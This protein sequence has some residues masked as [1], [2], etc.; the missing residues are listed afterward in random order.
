MGA[1]R[2]RPR[3]SARV[4]MPMPHGPVDRQTVGA[5]ADPE[6]MAVLLLEMVRIPSPT[7]HS[8][9][10]ACHYAEQLRTLGMAVEMSTEFRGAPS[11]VAR[12]S[13]GGPGPVL[14]FNGHLDTVP[15]PHA[16]P[17]REGSR[18]YGRGAADMKGGLVAICEAVRLLAARREALRGEL[19]VVAHGLHEAPTG[20]GEDLAALVRRGVKGDA[21]I[22]AE[23]ASTILPVVGKGNVVFE[24]TIRR[25]G[26][27]THEVRTPPGTPNP[28]LLAA[29]VV[30]G[31]AARSRELASAPLP[32]VG[33]ETYFVGMLHSG[34][35]YN[36]FPTAAQITGTR[37]YG[38]RTG[39]ARVRQELEEVVAHAVEG[40]D[41]VW[42]VRA[43]RDRDAFE[44]DPL[45]PI[46]AAVRNA[47][48]EVT[49]QPL[50][51]GGVSIVGDVSI[52]VNDGGIPAVYHG[53][54]GA[55]AHGDVEWIEVNELV[56]AARVYVQAARH[57]LGDGRRAVA[58]D[59]SRVEEWA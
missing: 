9:A 8:G 55:G 30:R 20:Y 40:H 29:E 32:H 49:G 12:L 54:Q 44:L 19:L 51:L 18:I 22:V 35:F 16:P 47:Y 28:L 7:G 53:P 41:V 45:S 25:D 57:Y 37:R 43:Q 42:E 10:A 38:V 56:R 5:D 13:L 23:G 33:P 21:A 4:M 15:V 27:A 6:R 11:V 17:R 26:E 52:F 50:P 58:D 14:E 2:R 1:A 48:R 46:V 24:V 3:D 39:F 34:D 31:M 36:R 59:A